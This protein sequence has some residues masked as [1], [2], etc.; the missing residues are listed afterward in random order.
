MWKKSK[1]TSIICYL[2]VRSSWPEV[3]T[4]SRFQRRRRC[5]R[6]CSTW[7][8]RTALT[9]GERRGGSSAVGRRDSRVF[10]WLQRQSSVRDF[11][12][13]EVEARCWSPALGRTLSRSLWSRIRKR[14]RRSSHCGSHARWRGRQG[15]LHDN[16]KK[17]VMFL[18]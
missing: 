1:W 18:I 11:E 9:W 14:R 17:S 8:G 15:L 10:L 6:K 2:G 13:G 7:P 12:P 3:A 16:N 5:R 4:K